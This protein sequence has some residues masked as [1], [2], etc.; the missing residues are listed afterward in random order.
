[1]AISS[2]DNY[3]ASYKQ[4]VGIIKAGG[5]SRTTVA[6]YPFSLFELVGNPGGGTL[7]GTS[8]SAGVVPTD[9]TPGCPIINNFAGGATGY[10]TKVE[11][12]ATVACRLRLYDML[13]KAGAYSYAGGTTSLSLQPSFSSRVPS[14]TDYKETEIWIE[15]VTGFVTGNTWSVTCNY[16]NQDGATAHTTATITPLAAANLTIGRMH[17]LPLAAGDTGVQKIENVVVTN[18]GTLMTAGTFNVLVLRKLWE[19]RVN[20]AN[21]GDTHD[22]LKTGM[23]QVFGDSAFFL[24]IATDSTSSGIPDINFEVASA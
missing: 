18:G 20:L 1:M 13:F 19:G 3:I 22:L 21:A 2:L 23:P 16:T 9:A 24:Q 6:T 8:T 12:T 10:L 11:F 15:I 5:T 7:A 14:G 4:R 17:Q